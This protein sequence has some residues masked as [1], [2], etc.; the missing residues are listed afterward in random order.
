M[1]KALAKQ[2][3]RAKRKNAERRP[4]RTEYVA[5]Y[6]DASFYHAERTG[7]VACWLRSDTKRVLFSAKTPAYV[8]TSTDAEIYG[9]CEA[10]RLAL[11][12]KTATV[13]VVKTDCLAAVDVF[14]A[15]VERPVSDD[16]GRCVLS[17]L[18]GA[19]N[20]NVKLYVKW[21][22]GHSGLEDTPSYL[23]ARVDDLAKRASIS[24][25]VFRW[26]IEVPQHAV[27]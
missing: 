19:S 20:R 26:E 24:G 22:K 27:S 2:I 6:S 17:V 7:G 14:D 13:I 9:V 15:K 1:D 4:G 25:E 5:G 21:V 18:H 8:K 3:R 23:N 12:T 11:E 10:I 16:L